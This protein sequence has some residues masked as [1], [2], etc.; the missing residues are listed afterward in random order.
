[1]MTSSELSTFCACAIF[2]EHAMAVYSTDFLK[3]VDKGK[4]IGVFNILAFMYFSPSCLC[5]CFIY[6][7]LLFF[8]LEHFLTDFLLQLIFINLISLNLHINTM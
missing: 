3:S 5:L 7:N 1:V 2:T 8:L 6:N 4:D